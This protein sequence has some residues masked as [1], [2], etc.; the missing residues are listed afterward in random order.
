MKKIGS[1]KLFTAALFGML[2]AGAWLVQ[3]RLDGSQ[4]AKTYLGFMRTYLA[5]GIHPVNFREPF[6]PLFLAGLSWVGLEPVRWVSLVQS[7][8][9]CSALF[10]F[11]RSLFPRTQNLF[12][13]ACL[14]A[15]LPL[16]LITI[17]GALY[18]ESTA[19]T[20]VLVQLG[21]CVRFFKKPR[22]SGLGWFF[23][24]LACS[25]CL[26]F[27]KGSFLYVNLLFPFVLLPCLRRYGKRALVLSACLLACGVADRVALGLWFGL[28]PGEPVFSHRTYERG[29]A[30]ASGRA[31]YADSF[32]FVKDSGPY[33]LN[34][35]SASACR[36]VLGD[37]CEAKYGWSAEWSLGW[38][39]REQLE[40]TSADPDGELLRRSLHLI[41][42]SPLR[43][44]AFCFYEWARFVFHHSTA[45]FAELRLGWLG[46]ASRSLPFALALKLFN[47]ALYLYLPFQLWKR[48]RSLAQ[49]RQAF[50][51]QPVETQVG[52]TLYLSYSASLLLIHGFILTVVR[53]CYP[54]TVF[55]VVLNWQ[56]WRFFRA[57]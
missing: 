26:G 13:V 27:N 55:L 7:V 10:F 6:Y 5:Q 38:D 18:T 30:I 15:L 29:G 28:L 45:G 11:L 54:V 35:F 36:R 2:L 20:L 49:L 19:A 42:A 4:D 33:L 21:C 14:V 17:N 37:D 34:A 3:P 32:S 23:G 50:L 47:L 56:G 44:G 40:K 9:F 31:L 16:F 22:G 52:T 39:A 25:I 24:V 48:R 41:L 1:S 51:A 53:M 43:Q 8:L 12:R 46:R 57:L